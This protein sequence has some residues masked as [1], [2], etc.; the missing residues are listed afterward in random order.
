MDDFTKI[1]LI[2]SLVDVVTHFYDNRQKG[3]TANQQHLKGF[4][5]GMAFALVEL[6]ILARDD[7]ARILQ[8]LGK[9]RNVVTI[10]EAIKEAKTLNIAEERSTKLEEDDNLNQKEVISPKENEENS[11]ETKES[12]HQPSLFDSPADLDI[13]TYLRK[14]MPIN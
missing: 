4:S 14:N 2:N 1:K 13:P 6:E 5:E 10:E 8:G 3:I 12:T 11:T 9:K 7:A